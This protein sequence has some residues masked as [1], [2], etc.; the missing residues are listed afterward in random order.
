L[1]S[2]SPL[3]AGIELPARGSR[4]LLG[5]I[6]QALRGLGCPGLWSRTMNT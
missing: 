6:S 2:R 3:L 4:H 1:T 5:D